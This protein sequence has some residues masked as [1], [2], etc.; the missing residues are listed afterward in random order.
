MFLSV[1]YLVY[2]SPNIT[3]PKSISLCS[4]SIRAFLQVQISGMLILPV[5]DKIGKLELISVFNWGVNVIVMVVERPA[6][7]RP[8]GVY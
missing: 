8:D 7:I 4:T 5:S 3:F 2:C 6:D 1:R